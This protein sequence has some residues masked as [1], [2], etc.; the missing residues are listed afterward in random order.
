MGVSRDAVR[1]EIEAGRW[2]S[3][4]RHTVVVI[5]AAWSRRAAWW[6]AVWESGAGAALDGVA[7]LHASGLTGFETDVIDVALPTNNRRHTVVGVRLRH[8][9]TM[10]PTMRGGIPRVVPEHAVL[11]AAQWAKTPRMAALLLCLVVQQR[12]VHPDRLLAAF[13]GLGRCRRRAFLSEV[14]ADICDGAHSLGELDFGRL[15]RRYGLPPPSRQVLRRLPNGRV[16]LDVSWDDVDLV[17]EI[18]GGHHYDA[19]NPVADAIRQ[20]EVVLAGGTVLR[21]PSLGLKVAEAQFMTQVVR[22]YEA[23]PP[24]LSRVG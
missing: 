3:A 15:C 6:R 14:L 23:A 18:D 10:P 19:L 5:R 8:Y 7:A 20:N 17:I 24:R 4:G 11:H 12:I 9:R 21:V 16:Y 13:G 22:A 1:G 2:V